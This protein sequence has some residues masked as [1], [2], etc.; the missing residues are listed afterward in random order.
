MSF[1]FGFGKYRSYE[2]DDFDEY[3]DDECD[4]EYGEEFFYDEE[5]SEDDIY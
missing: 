3:I 4:Y 5:Y 2:P 1:S